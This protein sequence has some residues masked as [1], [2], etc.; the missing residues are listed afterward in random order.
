ML[1][2][3]A[4]CSVCAVYTACQSQAACAE[5]LPSCSSFTALAVAGARLD[6]AVGISQ[7]RGALRLALLGFP[8][9]GPASALSAPLGN[10]CGLPVAVLGLLKLRIGKSRGGEHASEHGEEVE[11]DH[12]AQEEQGVAEYLVLEEGFQPLAEG[13]LFI[14]FCVSGRCRLYGRFRFLQCL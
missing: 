2:W 6:C 10:E 4:D 14:W 5:G 8:D 12:A 9:E 3:A 7:S 1:Q 11:E 13:L